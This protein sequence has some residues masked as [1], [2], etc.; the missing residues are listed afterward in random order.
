MT[1]VVLPY[2]PVAGDPEDVSQIMADF[3]AILTV[4][5]GDVRNDNISALA[6]IAITKLAGGNAGDVLEMAGSVPT[7]TKACYAKGRRNA[8]QTLPHAA[9]TPIAFDVEDAD[10]DTMLDVSGGTPSRIVAKTAGKFMVAGQVSFPAAT[11]G[12]RYAYIRKGGSIILAGAEVNSVTAPDNTVINPSDIV[13]LAVGEYV[14]IIGY[15]VSGGGSLAGCAGFL[16][17][18]RMGA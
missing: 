7:W 9:H 1:Q 17:A 16:S 15:Q 3:D 18:Y 14:E 2:R 8:G 4:L 5:N 11:A 12:P 13:P 10:T 6:A